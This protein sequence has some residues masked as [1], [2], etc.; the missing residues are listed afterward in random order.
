MRFILLA[1]FSQSILSFRGDLLKELKKR[2]FEIHIIAPFL[3]SSGK[4]NADDLEKLGFFIHNLDISRRGLNPITDIITFCKLLKIISSIKAD[5]ILSYTIKPVIYGTFAAFVV[6]VKKR[7]VLITGLGHTFTQGNQKMPYP[8]VNFLTRLMMRFSIK[9]SSGIIFQNKD[10]LKLLKKLNVVKKSKC[11]GVVNGSGI[12]INIY[13]RKPLPETLNFLFIGRFIETK[14]VNEFLKAAEIAKGKNLD[15]SFSIAGWNDSGVGSIDQNYI[16]LMHKK[17][18]IYNFGF[19]ED[20]RPAIEKS[21]VFVL[22]SYREGVPRSTLEAMSMGR[23]VITT[24]VPGCKETVI[25]GYNGFLIKKGSVN[26]LLEKINIFINNPDLIPKM[27][28]QS[29]NLV[30]EKY[31]VKIINKEMLGMM[32]IS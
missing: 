24:D 29:H 19:L 21:S 13:E 26:E 9:F 31:D 18:I 17:N 23:P 8:L 32:N 14:G 5:Y 10:D 27:G 6:G 2:G 22:P 25:D 4:R 3:G 30:K 20:V 28:E 1:S 15:I 12:N 16:E 7:F 11:L